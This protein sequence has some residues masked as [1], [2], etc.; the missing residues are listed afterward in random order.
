ML[1][2]ETFVISKKGRGQL[3]CY[4]EGIYP[5]PL[6]PKGDP[7][8]PRMPERSDLDSLRARGLSPIPVN[9]ERLSFSN[10]LHDLILGILTE[11]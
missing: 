3:C 6:I 2:G 11:L 7:T 10:A 5:G 9:A 8:F 1:G 4:A